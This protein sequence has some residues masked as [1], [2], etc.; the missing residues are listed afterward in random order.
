MYKYTVCPRI[1][2]NGEQWVQMGCYLRKREHWDADFWNNDKEFPNDGSEESNK[3]LD[4][5][6][7]ACMWLD[8]QVAKDGK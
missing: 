3:R 2:E 1:K 5:Y 4:A 7:F 8:S 6:K